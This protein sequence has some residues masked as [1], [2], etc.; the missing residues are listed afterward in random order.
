MK[1]TYYGIRGTNQKQ[2]I[3]D[4]LETSYVWDYEMD[5]CTYGEENEEELGGVCT[6]LVS[7]NLDNFHISLKII[8]SIRPFI[9]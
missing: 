9:G 4:V 1:Y 2:E 7:D 5:R 8:S 3:G 6:T